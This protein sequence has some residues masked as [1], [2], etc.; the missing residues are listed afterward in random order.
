[1]CL[2]SSALSKRAAQGPLEVLFKSVQSPFWPPSPFF[3]TPPP[4]FFPECRPYFEKFSLK[5]RSFFALCAAAPF[6]Q[7]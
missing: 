4:H 3:A 5:K 7:P 1:M 2:K 6:E